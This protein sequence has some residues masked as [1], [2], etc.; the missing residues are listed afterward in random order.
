MK[1][2]KENQLNQNNTEGNDDAFILYSLNNVIAQGMEASTLCDLARDNKLEELE[3]YLKKYPES[4]KNDNSKNLSPLMIASLNGHVKIME[5]LLKAGADINYASICG[6][7]I[8]SAIAGGYVEAVKFLLDNN[9]SLTN[10]HEVGFALIQAAEKANLT[11]DYAIFELLLSRNLDL[12]AECKGYPPIFHYACKQGWGEIVELLLKKDPILLESIYK[13]KSGKDIAIE[14]KHFYLDLLLTPVENTNLFRYKKSCDT[15]DSFFSAHFLNEYNTARLNFGYGIATFLTSRPLQDKEIARLNAYTKSHIFIN[16]RVNNKLITRN[17]PGFSQAITSIKELCQA[18]LDPEYKAKIVTHIDRLI[19]RVNYL[20]EHHFPVNTE[21]LTVFKLIKT[22]ENLEEELNKIILKKI[23][24]EK[25]QESKKAKKQGDKQVTFHKAADQAIT[26]D[27]K[28]SQVTNKLS[29]C[30]AKLA[31]L[32][33][34]CT[35]LIKEASSLV[36]FANNKHDPNNPHTAKFSSKIIQ[37]FVELEAIAKEINEVEEGMP[38]QE[39]LKEAKDKAA[40]ISELEEK[41]KEVSRKFNQLSMAEFKSLQNK[42][43]SSIEKSEIRFAEKKSS[44]TSK[45]AKG[46]TK[47][48]KN[49]KKK[50]NQNN[51][52]SKAVVP[53]P[54]KSTLVLQ[55]KPSPILQTSSSK[56]PIVNADTRR[57]G[58]VLPSKFNESEDKF[59]SMRSGSPITHSPLLI[60][61]LF[62]SQ[63]PSTSYAPMTGQELIPSSYGLFKKVKLSSSRVR[64]SASMRANY[65]LIQ[66]TNHELYKQRTQG[67]SSHLYRLSMLYHLKQYAVAVYDLAGKE[68]KTIRHFRD[69]ICHYADGLSEQDI[70]TYLGYFKTT[71]LDDMN[72]DFHIENMVVFLESKFSPLERLC[73]IESTG[74]KLDEHSELIL[75]LGNIITNINLLNTIAK[76][77]VYSDASISAESKLK[78]LSESAHESDVYGQIIMLIDLIGEHYNKVYRILSHIPS[79]NDFTNEYKQRFID[80]LSEF[81][82]ARCAISHAPREID[83]KDVVKIMGLVPTLQIVTTDIKENSIKTSKPVFKLGCSTST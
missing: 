3:A 33:K 65:H 45:N 5:V 2:N 14:N 9:A 13:G 4:I 48:K 23:E 24:I 58:R 11:Q 82:R 63:S 21:L 12:R 72:N 16:G 46:N 8:H 77:Y 57:E 7:A 41:I 50:R 67:D 79:T 10:P 32:K 15:C 73:L 17:T 76:N 56:P 39:K 29:V 78:I 49:T 60:N 68:N 54:A 69:L 71:C 34:D 25:K 83:I 64:E 66:L 18:I 6:S 22:S 81:Y 53:L 51:K 35:N 74:V 62:T 47:S 31:L 38:T 55:A 44:Y 20:I 36:E 26:E 43:K 75:K 30:V 59:T 52:K 28:L 61:G 70:S 19:A 40:I 1:Q 42:L 37:L 27:I 80:I